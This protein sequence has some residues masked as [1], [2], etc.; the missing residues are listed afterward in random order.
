MLRSRAREFLTGQRRPHTAEALRDT[1][2][3]L[4]DA[5]APPLPRLHNRYFSALRIFV[6]L[7]RTKSGELRLV[8]RRDLY[9]P[10]G[11]GCRVG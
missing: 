2:S 5:A 1:L 8:R 3:L 4:V 6:V 10:A 11:D 9:I 7:E